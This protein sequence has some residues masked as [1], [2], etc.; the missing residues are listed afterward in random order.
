[1]YHIGHE[2]EM[3][4]APILSVQPIAN[5]YLQLKKVAMV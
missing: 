4:V 3:T 2:S 5:T 1:M